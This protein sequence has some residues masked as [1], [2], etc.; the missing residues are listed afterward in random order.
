LDARRGSLVEASL[1][2][3]WSHWVGLGV[4]GV[5]RPPDTAVDVEALLYFTAYVADHDP[6]LRDEVADWWHQFEHH[7]S[8]PR[9]NAMA[10]SFDALQWMGFLTTFPS[11]K[12]LSG[13]SRLDRLDTPARSLLRMRAVFGANARADVLLEMLTSSSDEGWTALALSEIGYSKRNVAMVLE[14]LALG[15]LLTTTSE[16]N[17]ARYRLTDRQA[18]AKVLAPLP[19][20]SGHWHLRLP[21]AARFLE[22]ASRIERKDAVTQGIEAQKLVAKLQPE[23]IAVG[24]MPKLPNAAA[25]T[26][27]PALQVWIAEHLLAEHQDSRR[28][29][30]RT[31]EGVWLSPGETEARALR[32]DGAVLPR[33][34]AELDAE[35]LRCLDLVQVSTVSPSNDWTWGVLSRAATGTYRHS[36]GL[37]RGEIWRFVAIGSGDVYEVSFDE[38][39]PHERISRLYGPDA[40]ARA[41][42]DKPAVQL[43][44]RRK[45]LH[46]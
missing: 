3:A 13:K 18:L 28:D 29:I 43:R 30:S 20:R 21:I 36:M 41:R 9:F 45:R 19:Q 27:W 15:G 11:A 25:G 14:S 2:V 12:K 38:D 26:Y 1:D 39:L 7:V 37:D 44:L 42:A 40:A 34:S 8:G 31:L 5:A 23:L 33:L 17:R 4:R 32:P 46:R 16:S 35:E 6:R 10:R 24:G 22:L